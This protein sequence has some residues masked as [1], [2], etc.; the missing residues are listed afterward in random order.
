M[1]HAEAPYRFQPMTQDQ[2]NEKHASAIIRELYQNYTAT[3]MTLLPNS[4]PRSQALS[5][6]KE[7][8][9]WA[10]DALTYHGTTL[11]VSE[12]LKLEEAKE[13]SKACAVEECKST[14]LGNEM[15]SSPVQGETV[16]LE[17]DIAA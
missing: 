8:E 4:R 12:E 6:L 11:P 2:F 14:S 7:A 17:T 9:L 1:N 5:A 10:L 16:R 13:C 3:L 15:D